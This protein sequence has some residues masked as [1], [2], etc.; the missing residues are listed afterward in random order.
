[1]KYAGLRVNEDF[2]LLCYEKFDDITMKIMDYGLLYAWHFQKNYWETQKIAA[3]QREIIYTNVISKIHLITT[4][5]CIG[6]AVSVI[7]LIVECGLKLY[8]NKNRLCSCF[9]P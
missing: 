8:T 5:M 3:Q 2:V 6:Y 1:M 9:N 4:I 7:A